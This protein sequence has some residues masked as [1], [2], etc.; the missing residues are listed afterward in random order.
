[1]PYLKQRSVVAEKSQ[2]YVFFISS[3]FSFSIYFLFCFFIFIN[4]FI[5]KP[6]SACSSEGRS[7]IIKV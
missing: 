5:E 1:M 4:F 2:K 7:T 3:S 6:M